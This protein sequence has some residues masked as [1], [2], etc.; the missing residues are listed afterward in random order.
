MYLPLAPPDAAVPLV[1]RRGFS[2]ASGRVLVVDDDDVPRDAA[3]RILRSV[4]YGGMLI[5]LVSV[6][7]AITLLPVVLSSIGHKLDWPRKRTDDKA[8]SAWTRWATPWR[9]RRLR[10]TSCIWRMATGPF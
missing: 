2:H 9:S 10:T 8:S 1:L 7:V 5:P 6:L 4:G 3:A